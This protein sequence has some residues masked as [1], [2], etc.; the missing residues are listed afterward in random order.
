M[1]FSE[2]G[3]RIYSSNKTHPTV[4]VVDTT[5]L[6]YPMLS[7]ITTTGDDDTIGSVLDLAF[8]SDRSKLY[9][10]LNEGGHGTSESSISAGTAP[11]TVDIELVELNPAT[12]AVTNR[13]AIASQAASDNIR[14]KGIAITPDDSMAAIIVDHEDAESGIYFVDLAAMTIIDTDPV[15]AGT[16]PIA[17]GIDTALPKSVIFVDNTT[18]VVNFGGWGSGTYV[19]DGNGDKLVFIDTADFSTTEFTSAIT[20]TLGDVWAGDIQRGPDGKVYWT[21]SCFSNAP[22]KDALAYTGTEALSVIDPATKAETLVQ[23]G[24]D[25]ENTQTAA[26]GYGVGLAFNQDNSVLYIANDQYGNNAGV[27]ITKLNAS[28]LARMDFDGNTTD[29]IVGNSDMT[30]KISGLYSNVYAS[31]H[32]MAISPF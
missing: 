6:T 2:D 12:L 31:G 9:A 14:A 32:S 5:T 29:G 22:M 19:E 26:C 1:I 18:A 28:T 23:L 10:L 25:S 7:N 16:Q 30:Q 13:L 8:N 21:R 15:A 3:T 11:G 24:P 4:S 27:G 20:N 17:H